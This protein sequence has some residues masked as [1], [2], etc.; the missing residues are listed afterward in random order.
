MACRKAPSNW[1]F[2][3]DD[4]ARTVDAVVAQLIPAGP[5][6]GAREAG[7]VHYIDIQ[8][9]TRFRKHQKAYRE[10]LAN[11]DYISRKDYGKPFADLADDQ[12]IA[13]LNTVEERARTFFQLF[14]NHTRQGFYGDP[15]HGGNRDRV[16]WKLLG[17]P[18]PPVRGRAS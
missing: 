1:R 5:G 3:T 7:V 11:I 16:S 4:Q 2:F 17:L 14:L 6:P 13:A 15:R 12:Q 9:A 8:L 18:F 10:G